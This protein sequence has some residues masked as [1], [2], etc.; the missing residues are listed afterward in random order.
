MHLVLKTN[1]LSR[2]PEA[3]G[4]LT[5]ELTAVGGTLIDEELSDGEMASLTTLCDVYVSL[6]RAEGFGFGIAEAMYFGRPVVATAYSG[7]MDFM[8]NSNS[9]PVGYRIQPISRYDLRLN[10]GSESVYSP[11]EIWAEPDVHDAAR[12][13]R[14]LFE[15]PQF[16]QRIGNA[17]ARTIRER[18]GREVVGRQMR[19]RLEKCAAIL[20]IATR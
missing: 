3:Y 1:H 7:N 4:L 16:G 10:P 8:N 11:G 17:G 9:C 6:H 2:L 19:E 20:G 12:R 15:Q 13:M 18:Y 14:F 5:R